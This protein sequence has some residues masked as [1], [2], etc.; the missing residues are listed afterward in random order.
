M[1]LRAFILHD[2]WL[3]F[4]SVAL[5]AVIWM[6]IHYSIE[7]DFSLRELDVKHLVAQKY[8]RVPVS[9]VTA[10]GDSRVFRVAPT[11]V[12]VVALGE[13]MVLHGISQKNIRVHVDLTDF[14]VPKASDVELH[15]DVPRDVTVISINP[16]VVNVEQ[17][18]Q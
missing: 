15:A 3:K 2:F 13:E 9:I 5:A 17:T 12:E 14:Q 4:F 1:A 6:A 18:S 16:P 8:M 11:N 10:P 7:H